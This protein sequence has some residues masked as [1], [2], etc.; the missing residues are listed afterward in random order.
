MHHQIVR[1]DVQRVVP[2]RVAGCVGQADPYAGAGHRGQL[3][4]RTQSGGDLPFPLDLRGDVLGC[5]GI[6]LKLQITGSAL[7]GRHPGLGVSDHR[8]QISRPVVQVLAVRQRS[9]GA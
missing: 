2:V 5:S 4:G 3:G 7:T 8:G 9:G 1:I 6:D